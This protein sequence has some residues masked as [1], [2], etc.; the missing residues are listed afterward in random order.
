MD[1]PPQK[2]RGRQKKSTTNRVT[3]SI[4]EDGLEAGTPLMFVLPKGVGV[5]GRKYFEPLHD[6]QVYV[7]SRYTVEKGIEGEECYLVFVI[8]ERGREIS[9]GTNCY[10]FEIFG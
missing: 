7:F 6:H 1:D 10:F 2:M 4:L 8:D 5:G 3:P 9:E